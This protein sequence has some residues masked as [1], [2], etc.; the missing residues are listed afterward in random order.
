MDRV[1]GDPV[2]RPDSVPGPDCGRFRRRRSLPRPRKR[3]TP[4][5]GSAARARAPWRARGPSGPGTAAPTCAGCRR[6]GGRCGGRRRRPGGAGSPRRSS[7][8]RP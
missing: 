1:R 8:G 3:V 2:P 4:V 6:P 7:R 5:R